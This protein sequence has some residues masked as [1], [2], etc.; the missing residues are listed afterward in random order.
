MV[1][2]AVPA[3]RPAA[4]PDVAAA[5]G[6]F[7]VTLGAVSV[8]GFSPAARPAPAGHARWADGSY[9]YEAC[10]AIRK[11]VIDESSLGRRIACRRAGF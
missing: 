10:L 2:T 4:A 6:T 8:L 11:A 5:L 7:V 9:L 3:R 1:R